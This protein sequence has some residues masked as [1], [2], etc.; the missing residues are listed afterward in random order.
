MKI[1]IGFFTGARS[2]YGVTKKLIKRLNDDKN[3]DVKIFVSGM[4]LLNK[5]GNTFNE[6]I[7]DG[8]SIHKKI[9]TY[10]K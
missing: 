1:K 3:F 8:F 5:Y 10:Q 9:K 6:I 4:H 7:D 2:D